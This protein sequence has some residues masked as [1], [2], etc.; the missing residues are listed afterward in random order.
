MQERRSTAAL[1][2]ASENCALAMAGTLWSAA[3]LRRFSRRIGNNAWLRCRG[4]PFVSEQDSQLIFPLV[5][6]HLRDDDGR[7]S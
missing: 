6:L 2:D 5:R 7:F 3:V 1:Q 4:A